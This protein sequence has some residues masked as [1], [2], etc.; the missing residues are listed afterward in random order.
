MAKFDDAVSIKIPKWL[1]GFFADFL[2][3]A[4]EKY[5]TRPYPIRDPQ[6]AWGV[7]GEEWDEFKREVRHTKVGDS[8]KKVV[9]DTCE[10]SVVC[11]M[12]YVDL[13]QAEA[14]RSAR[15]PMTPGGFNTLCSA[16]GLRQ[17]WHETAD[18]RFLCEECVHG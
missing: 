16:C 12:A 9:H 6:Q 11:A 13:T 5:H 1:A 8:F 14:T 17:A 15:V 18:R 7:I 3:E 4:K 10:L 2:E